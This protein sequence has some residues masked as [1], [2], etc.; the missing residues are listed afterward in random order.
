MLLK[1]IF[2]LISLIVVLS[3]LSAPTMFLIKDSKTI[4]LYKMDIPGSN[5]QKSANPDY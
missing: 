4:P 5:K 3:V 1:I 2:L